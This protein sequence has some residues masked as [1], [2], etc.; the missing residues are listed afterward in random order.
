MNPKILLCD[1]AT[2]ALDPNTTNSILDL[3]AKINQKTGITVVIVT[4]QMEV[5]R[6]VCNK[7]S[8][9]EHGIIAAQGDVEEVFVCWNGQPVSGTNAVL[10]SSDPAV[11]EV[12]N[13]RLIAK[14]QVRQQL[15]CIMKA[16]GRLR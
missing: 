9:M 16:T 4:H 8:V 12:S 3:L 15:H 2:S 14:K 1:E 5:V 11:C 7:M 6:R 13:G 10:V